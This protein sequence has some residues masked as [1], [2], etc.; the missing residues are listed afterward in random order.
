MCYSAKAVANFFIRK[1]LEDH[2]PLTHLQ[3]QKMVFFAHAVYFKKYHKPLI[4][5]PV[6]AWKYGPVIQDLYFD[7][8][9]YGDSPITQVISG[10]SLSQNGEEVLI[11]TP[12][13]N[14]KDTTVIDFLTRAYNSLHDMSGSRLCSISHAKGGAWYKTLEE[15]GL[16]PE[17]ANI[18]IPR[19]LVILDDAIEEC[20]K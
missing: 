16:N 20:G 2:K 14:E 6:F 12:G 1:S 11:S 3:L 18:V 13:I 8:K 19:N 10:V 5:D 7:L 4:T 15:R 9:N 17:D